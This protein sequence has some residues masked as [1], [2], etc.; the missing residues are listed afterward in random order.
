M[1]Y[2]YQRTLLSAWNWRQIRDEPNKMSSDETVS[3]SGQMNGYSGTMQ[4]NRRYFL[5]F[6]MA[7]RSYCTDEV[8][9]SK[10]AVY[11]VTD[12]SCL[13]FFIVLCNII[14]N[15]LYVCFRQTVLL[16]YATLCEFSIFSG[17]WR[18]FRIRLVFPVC[19]YFTT[20]YFALFFL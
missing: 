12:V 18:V 4:L 14:C 19:F 13:F 1:R 17:R 7:N 11:S 16:L 10:D 15:C 9:G 8:F 2:T 20:Y 6:N 3:F 5:L